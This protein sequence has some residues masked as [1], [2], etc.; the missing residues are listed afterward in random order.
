MNYSLFKPQHRST[1]AFQLYIHTTWFLSSVLIILVF[2]LLVQILSVSYC[3]TSYARIPQWRTWLAS[4]FRSP[5]EWSTWHRRSLCTE[6]WQH[7][8]A[9]ESA[10]CT[11]VCGVQRAGGDSALLPKKCTHTVH[12]SSPCSHSLWLYHCII[13][14]AR[15]VNSVV[16]AENESMVSLYRYI[17]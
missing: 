9:C 14:K 17:P 13:L 12:L 6:I 10:P 3:V 4:G 7:A 5:R 8:T 1:D 11:S 15:A 16:W 2:F